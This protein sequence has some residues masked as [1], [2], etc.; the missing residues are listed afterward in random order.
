MSKT[1][2]PN[3]RDNSI[4]RRSKSISIIINVAIFCSNPI[5]I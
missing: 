3:P 4:E 1:I 2:V 5:Q